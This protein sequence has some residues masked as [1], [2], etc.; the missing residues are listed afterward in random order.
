[1]SDTSSA[2]EELDMSDVGAALLDS[3]PA[4]L[5]QLSMELANKGSPQSQS[6]LGYVDGKLKTDGL[7]M[8]IT[9]RCLS[10]LWY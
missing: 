8:L 3:S 6:E 5:E 4:D 10:T 7:K 9:N 2:L 1:M